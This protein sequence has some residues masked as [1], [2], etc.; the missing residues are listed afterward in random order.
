MT[1]LELVATQDLIAALFSRH[2]HACFVGLQ[3]MDEGSPSRQATVRRWVG[4]SYT[5]M[6]LLQDTAGAIREEYMQRS[7]QG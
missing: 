2:D 5:I 4:N 3:I 1:D 6:G 7:E